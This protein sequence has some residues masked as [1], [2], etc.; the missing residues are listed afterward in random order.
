MK[1]LTPYLISLTMVV[2]FSLVHLRIDTNPNLDDTLSSYGP[3]RELDRSALD[4]KFNNQSSDELPEPQV[5][6]A[7]IDE[8]SVEKYGLWPW[9]RSL[10]GDF[11]R[12]AGEGGAAVIAFD[13]AFVDEDR[14]NVRPSVQRLRQKLLDSKLGPDGGLAVLEERL[15]QT[16]TAKERQRLLPLIEDLRDSS[17][18]FLERLDDEIGVT[19]PDELMAAAIK[20][21]QIPC[22][23]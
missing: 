23:V 6:I 21:I 18:E 5:V 2:I 3:I 14:N 22:L 9:P 10:T 4:F 17:R 20:T 12:T 8:K 16:L 13:V 11:I 1:K 19:N 7:S 15:Q